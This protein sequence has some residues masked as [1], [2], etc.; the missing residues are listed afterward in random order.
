LSDPDNLPLTE[1][2]LRRFKRAVPPPDARA[3]RSATGLSQFDFAWRYGFDVSALR[4]WEQGR[5][6]P[7]RCA[8]VL[9]AVIKYEPRAVERAL[10]GWALSR[11][12]KRK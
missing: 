3:I 10:A 2:Q 5:R 8:R 12:D 6:T 7:D 4:D 9:L 1:K 11:F